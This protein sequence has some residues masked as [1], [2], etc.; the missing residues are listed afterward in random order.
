MESGNERKYDTFQS[1][2]DSHLSFFPEQ[3]NRKHLKWSITGVC[4]FG[5]VVIVFNII[6][7]SA[8]YGYV[9]HSD[10]ILISPYTNISTN[11]T[12]LQ[13]CIFTRLNASYS[14]SDQA[15]STGGYCPYE[16][17]CNSVPVDGQ[18]ARVCTNNNF[19]CPN[20]N[21]CYEFISDLPQ[22]LVNGMAIVES[23]VGVNTGNFVASIVISLIL[24]ICFVILLMIYEAWC[25]IAGD[26]FSDT[27]GTKG[28]AHSGLAGS[29]ADKYERF[30]DDYL[31]SSPKKCY[32][33]IAVSFYYFF[34]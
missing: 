24:L 28:R 12:Y 15:C 8:T 11:A 31:Q 13:P 4:I 3:S 9:N 1:S 25:I 5:C 14:A 17:E 18:P 30:F 16:W 22:Y 27:Y 29:L 23:D 32:F 20:D 34:L 19:E 7:A 33:I 10:P 2:Q 21:Q 6:L 26:P